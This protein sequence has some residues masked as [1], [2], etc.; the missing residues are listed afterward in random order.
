M[1]FLLV[2]VAMLTLVGCNGGG[3]NTT[4]SLPAGEARELADIKVAVYEYAVRDFHKHTGDVLILVPE[5]GPELAY[6]QSCL[7]PRK[8]E[9]KNLRCKGTD[10]EGY[11]IDKE[12]GKG[13][14]VRE[15]RISAHDS[16]SATAKTS[17][18]YMDVEPLNKKEPHGFIYVKMCGGG[19]SVRLSKTERGWVVVE[20]FD[21]LES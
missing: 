12:T 5:D 10:E 21:H 1:R 16:N 13:A 19:L 8:I 2:C 20:E 4:S 3:L 11:I 17:W 9:A 14:W 7:L 15:A 6:I 18:D